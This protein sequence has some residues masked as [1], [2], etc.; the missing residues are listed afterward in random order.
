MRVPHGGVT[1]F[2]C[3]AVMAAV[4]LLGAAAQSAPET[5]PWRLKPAVAVSEEHDNNLYLLA[6][7]QKNRLEAPPAGSPPTRFAG[8]AK[9]SD[10][11]TKIRAD[12]EI[13]G[14]GFG[15]RT[16]S[17]TPALGY[18]HYAS[19]S[20]RSSSQLGLT[21]AQNLGRGSRV[22]LK[23]DLD[24]TTFFKNYL[25]DAVDTDGSGSI[26]VGER[27]YAAG[28]KAQRRIGADYR[29]RLK[30]GRKA[31]PTDIFLDLRAGHEA[32]TYG[33]PFAVRDRAGPV[34]GLG[35]L[36][37]RGRAELE[38]DYEFASMQATPG[39]AVRLLDEPDF[40]VDFNGNGLNTDLNA[41]AFEMVDY[42]RTEHGFGVV[43]RVPVG[44]RTRVQ[45]SLGHRR[46]SFGST[47]PYDV[48]NRGRK[49]ARNEVGAEVAF[50]VG[51]AVRL[52]AEF[53]AQSQK[54][55]KPLDTAGDVTDYSRRRFAVGVAYSP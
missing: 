18:D 16:L 43:G 29:H 14:A 17:I 6:P 22:R 4:P 35:L 23:A 51:P 40:G 45:L 46:R 50:K 5:R 32:Q 10:L 36:F 53:N 34:A 2:V 13:S 15:G 24:P 19:N 27:L 38:V 37:D 47:Q 42:S 33:A 49:D 25:S 30:N 21:V 55:N 26:A 44:S 54:V 31:S 1:T 52:I 8:M 20:D 11:L 39:R 12:L 3:S 9:P 41:R 28:S 7:N 48:G